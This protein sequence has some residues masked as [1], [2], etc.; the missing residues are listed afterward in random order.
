[1]LEATGDT[2]A[3]VAALQPAVQRV[4]IANLLQ[5]RLIAEARVKGDKI[6]AAILA[7]LDGNGFLP[8]VW[9]ADERS[10][11]LRRH[12]AQIV[13]QRAR[14]K[15]EIHSVL[16]AHLIARCTATDLFAK[17]SRASLA[18]QPLPIDEWIGVEQ[19]LRELDRLGEDPGVIDRGLAQRVGL[20][21]QSRQRPD[22]A[23]S[24]QT[25]RSYPK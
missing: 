1:M 5:V 8:E 14:L 21:N 23:A 6:D 18:V 17:R 15:N 4:V 25:R 2:A 11:A 7:R 20:T 22:C 19:R 24:A 9:I 13:R 3:I 16:A 10:Q 12:V